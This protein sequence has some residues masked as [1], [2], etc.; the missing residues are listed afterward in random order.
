MIRAG[1]A[2]NLESPAAAIGPIVVAVLLGG[3]AIGQA[4][5]QN[6]CGTVVNG[7]S[8]ATIVCNGVAGDAG[9]DGS[10]NVVNGSDTGDD[11]SGLADGVAIDFN[12]LTGGP[13]ADL[14]SLTLELDGTS[15][16]LAIG[17]GLPLAGNAVGFQSEASASLADFTIRTLGEVTL[18]GASS[19]LNGG[20]YESFGTV[21]FDL[22]EDTLIEPV[23][24][25]GNGD[26]IRFIRDDGVDT[27]P[28]AG[29]AIGDTFFTLAGEIRSTGERAIQTIQLENN[30]ASGDIFVTTT[31]TSYLESIRV[32]S[33]LSSLDTGIYVRQREFSDRPY[34]PSGSISID[35]AGTIVAGE[36]NADRDN[37]NA[38]GILALNDGIGNT[39]ILSV[40]DITTYGTTSEAIWGLVR[41][42]GNTQGVN[43]TVD[44]GT[45]T[46][47]GADS[48]AV[49]GLVNSE[50][51]TGVS[52]VDINAGSVLASG[53]GSFGAASWSVGGSSTLFVDTAVTGGSGGGGGVFGGA[54]T[55]GISM[56]D[57][58]ANGVISAFSEFAVVAAGGEATVIN[59]GTIFGNVFLTDQGDV[60]TNNSSTS[61]NIRNFADTDGDLIRDTE[62]VAVSDFAGGADTFTNTASGLV[63]L[64]TVEDMAGNNPIFDDAGQYLPPSA[65]SIE[66]VGVEQAQI[67]N[68]EQFQHMGDLVLQDT[69]AG[70][71]APVAG[72]VLVVS[73][74]GSAGSIGGGVYEPMGGRILLDSVLD[75]GGAGSLSDVLV[76]DNV[77]VSSDPTQVRIINADP[78]QGA[79]TD[80]NGNGEVD[81][82]EGILVIEVLG[83]SPAG[84][85]EMMPML[86]SGFMYELLQD[87][88]GN[89]VLWSQEV[90]SVPMLD[91]FGLVLLIAL[92]GIGAVAGRRRLWS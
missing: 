68:L 70:N 91:R 89:W 58:G 3:L 26:G 12:A 15:S 24:S 51:S 33:N 57:I 59:D 69:Q 29:A 14:D 46:T 75:E 17:T 20:F 22:S 23:S 71:A 47:S 83:D 27:G 13:L 87:P 38:D 43:I 31:N 53:A 21:T 92:L 60:F 73:G 48:I 34:V 72:D 10:V 56:I 82:G 42:D 7:A 76:L 6:E 90:I 74:S 67:L 19:G 16:A 1:R 88:E 49:Y 84:A 66:A 78:G 36:Q 32:G 63:R 80:T 18:G 30:E 45:I 9:S 5:A 61:W 2:T 41:G 81:L 11:A 25:G 85:F 35:A 64:V 79:M 65:R 44:G 39:S 77:A 37:T 40:A 55:T 52:S 50:T 86:D 28:G 8:S 62:A 4:H 54:A